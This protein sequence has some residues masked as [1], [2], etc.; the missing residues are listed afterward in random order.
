[1]IRWWS[2]PVRR[3]IPL[4]LRTAVLAGL[5]AGCSNEPSSP[6]VAGSVAIRESRA[7]TTGITV[8]STSPDSATRDTTLDVTIAGSGFASDAVASWALNGAID[9][10]QVRTNS[11]RYVNQNKLVANIT[12][13]STATIGS[14]DVIVTTGKKSGIGSDAFAI[15]PSVPSDTWKLPLADA[16]LSLKSDRQYSDGTY[17]VYAAGVCNV[18]GSIFTGEDGST[19]NSGDATIQTSRPSRGKCGRL[20]T[21]VYPDGFT[22]T[23]ASFNN[24]NL[25]E[26]TTYAIPFG[27]TVMRR[28][29]VNPG[30]L[31][32]NPSRCGRLLF[33]LGPLGDKGIGSDSVAV[34]RIDA[35]TWQVQSQAAP[36]NLVL[37]ENTGQLY[38]M[39]VSFVAVSS[40]PLR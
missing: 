2:N 15:K 25:L 20:F 28:L 30:V 19:N 33:G 11:T 7:T 34:T 17:S 21:I 24:L 12:I 13:S 23:L 29:V 35:S 6:A 16:G 22:E 5:I 1:M 8:T 36:N 39:Q 14:W 32:N 27:T 4:V 9:A 40:R 3:P 31:A 10:T 38:H 26:N 37:C 18:T